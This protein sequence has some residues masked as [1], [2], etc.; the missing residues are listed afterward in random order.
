[1]LIQRMYIGKKKLEVDL[2]QD[3]SPD[4]QNLGQ[5]IAPPTFST[6]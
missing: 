5:Y 6:G 1:M 4:L 3:W 2:T